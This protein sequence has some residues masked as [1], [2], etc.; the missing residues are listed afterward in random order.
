MGLARL[1][2]HNEKV[3][4]NTEK[5]HHPAPMNRRT[6]VSSLAVAG[7][8]VASGS[9]LFSAG[10]KSKPTV[11]IIGCGWFGGVILESF[12]INSAVNFISLCDVNEHSLQATLKLVAKFQ[13]DIPKT[14]ADYRE[15]LAA[16]QHDIIIVATP[17]HWH[18]V[19]CHHTG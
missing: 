5:P 12:A 4:A 11:G 6:F 9:R 18:A 13:T 2:H 14:F 10:Q 16:G 15:M 19:R 17:D 3:T 8:A 1:P 7:A